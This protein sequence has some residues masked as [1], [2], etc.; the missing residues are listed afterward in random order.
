M[1]KFEKTLIENMLRATSDTLVDSW[2]NYHAENVDYINLLRTPELTMKIY[3]IKTPVKANVVNPHNHRYDS[4]SFILK[5]RIQ[6]VIYLPNPSGNE[7]NKFLYTT[8]LSNYDN[9]LPTFSHDGTS[10][11]L[12]SEDLSHIFGPS[13]QFSLKYTDIHT[14]RPVTPEVVLLQFQYSA[15][16][17][18]THTWFKES[19]APSTANLYKHW[20]KHDLKAAVSEI[21]V[22]LDS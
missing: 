13:E 6:N 17:D 5:G 4:T 20:N 12:E 14:I 19:T 18:S 2:R 15:K 21:R 9:V 10:R 3:F 16:T 22:L 7:W 8:G 11:L 1:N